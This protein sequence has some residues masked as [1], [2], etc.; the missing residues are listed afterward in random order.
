[1]SNPE[2]KEHLFHPPEVLSGTLGRA[3]VVLLPDGHVPEE[4]GDGHRRS[5]AQVGRLGSYHLTGVING[6]HQGYI[7]HLCAGGDAKTG[8]GCD[9][10][11][12]FSAKAVA[13]QRGEV[14]GRG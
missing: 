6:V 11:E 13:G 9:R 12:G 8:D 14:C 2:G 7:V 4:V 3:L 1:M 5:S 10:G